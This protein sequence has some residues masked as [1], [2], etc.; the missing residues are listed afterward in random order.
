MRAELEQ[1]PQVFLE[2]IADKLEQLAMDSEICTI[3]EDPCGLTGSGNAANKNTLI[4]HDLDGR[5]PEEMRACS[6]RI[7]HDL[8]L[9]NIN[10]IGITSASQRRNLL[11]NSFIQEFTCRKL[12]EAVAHHGETGNDKALFLLHRNPGRPN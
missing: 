1:T 2:E 3:N 8:L 10:L 6:N 4:H 5:T 11:R 9:R 7:V 12:Q